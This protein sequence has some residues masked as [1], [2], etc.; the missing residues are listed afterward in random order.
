MYYFLLFF[1]VMLLV[2]LGGGSN[3][4]K[5]VVSLK[6]IHL[7]VF[8]SL[9][10]L[11]GT[12]HYSVGTDTITYVGEF[13]GTSTNGNLRQILTSATEPLY[14]LTL[15]I[16]KKFTSNYTW[17]LI[18]FSFPVAWGFTFLI[19]KYSDDYLLSV[20]LFIVL[21]IFGF[22]MA[23]IRQAAALGITMLSYYFIKEKKLVKFLLCVFVAYGFHNSALVY[24]LAYVFVNI[25]SIKKITSYWIMTVICLC[26]GVVRNPIVLKLA[27][28][29]MM[30]DRFDGYTQGGNS[31]LNYTMFIIQAILLL[32]SC[33][34]MKKKQTLKNEGNLK[35]LALSF[36][37]LCFQAFTPIVGEF[38]RVSMYFSV[39]QCILVPNV[40][41]EIENRRTKTI[42]YFG[43]LAVSFMYI[44][45]V[46]GTVTSYIP[47]WK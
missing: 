20:L 16:C 31:G 7:V 27:Q 6:R 9:L 13:L 43:I 45:L 46:Q 26:L 10:F 41:R 24:L 11:M 30:E 42:V 2:V 35:L 44:F 18:V 19:K 17:F 1:L 36:V 32:F 12:R 15:W 4:C 29:M 23:G 40:I 38:F 25:L 5:N 22:C 33:L 39:Y 34:Y 8:F 3:I 21:G 47:F 14:N 28:I 37:G